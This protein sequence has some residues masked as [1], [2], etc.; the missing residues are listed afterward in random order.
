MPRLTTQYP[1]HL[2]AEIRAAADQRAASL[3][4]SLRAY[5]QQLIEKDLKKA[6][7]ERRH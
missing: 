5:I 2:P 1:L 3:G 4:L 7:H 6:K